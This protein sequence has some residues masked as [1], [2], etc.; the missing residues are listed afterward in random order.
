MILRKASFGFLI[1]TISLINAQ[2]LENLSKYVNPL[3]GTEKMGH[4]YPGATTPFGAVQLSPETDSLAYNIKKNI[5]LM[6]IN[7][8]LVTVTKT[9]R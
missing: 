3:I 5:I 8:V 2:K 7:I 1:F 9:R 4:T 6:F